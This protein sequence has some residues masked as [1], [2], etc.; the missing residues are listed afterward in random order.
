MSKT[1]ITCSRNTYISSESKNGDFTGASK[2][3]TSRTDSSETVGVDTEVTALLQFEIPKEVQYKQVTKAAL[4]YYLDSDWPYSTSEYIFKGVGYTPYLID[5]ITD[6]ITYNNVAAQGSLGENKYI[7][8]EMEPWSWYTE[9]ITDIFTN[10][11]VNG[12]Y[13]VFVGVGNHVSAFIASYLGSIASGKAAYLEVT[14]EE[15]EQLPPTITYPVDVYVREGEPVLFSWVYNSLTAATQTA[16]TLEWKAESATEYNV[17]NLTQTGQSYL[18]DI[19]FPAG[20]IDWRI[21]V[22]NDIGETS[23]YSEAQFVVIGKPAIPIIT[24]VKNQALTEITWNASDQCVYEI[25]ISNATGNVLVS[26]TVHSG[27]TS[28][29][30]QMFLANGT[31]N[32]RLRTKNSIELWS[33]YTS[34][35]VTISAVAPVQ[36]TLALYPENNMVRMKVEHASGT[37]AAILRSAEYE[38]YEVIAV[39]EDGITEY[40]DKEIKSG[41]RYAYKALAYN[42]GYSDS[43]VRSTSTEFDGIYLQ[44][45]AGTLHLT[46]TEEK[47]MPHTETVEQEMALM[48]YSGRE[49]P[50]AEYG[51]HRI[52]QAQKK[53]Y[54]SYQDKKL[55]EDICRSEQV[56]YRDKDGNAFVCAI[57]SVQYTRYMDMGYHVSFVVSEVEKE[58]VVLNV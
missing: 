54:I 17:I 45:D 5:N 18:A 57:S 30:P 9:D 50:V 48:K 21:K 1:T 42:T 3:K 29:K 26:E 31:Y 15:V 52:R 35:T 43:A 51:E 33:D 58:E 27:E 20:T 37:K 2:L 19:D 39:L 24:E 14:F 49:L 41:V 25:S 47:Y 16:V 34:K 8:K 46:M 38:A 36:P 55:F 4:H 6:S 40:V 28:Y 53:A 11:I 44:S 23:S 7:D 32:I 10:N 13:S 56:F 12:V 22:T